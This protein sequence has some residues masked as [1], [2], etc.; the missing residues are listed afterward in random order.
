MLKDTNDFDVVKANQ[1][2]SAFRQTIHNGDIAID[3]SCSIG[4]AFFQRDG[5]TYN[6]LVDNAD[7]ALYEAKSRGK[8][9]FKIYSD[10]K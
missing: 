7:T 8:N 4:I 3:I 2:C 1:I 6:E 5:T 10:N 9:C